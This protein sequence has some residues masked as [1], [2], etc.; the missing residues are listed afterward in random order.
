MLKLLLV[1]VL[2]VQLS[3]G[4]V[5]VFLG[6]LI[7]EFTYLLFKFW[8]VICIVCRQEERNGILL[9]CCFIDSLGCL[10]LYSDSI[11][12]TILSKIL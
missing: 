9:G 12:E 10:F 2:D 6:C 11:S 3:V 1:K 4:C 5:I 7:F 8:K